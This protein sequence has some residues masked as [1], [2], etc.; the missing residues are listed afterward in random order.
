MTGRY[1]PEFHRL[2]SGRDRRVGMKD[3]LPRQY[4]RTLGMIYIMFKI[5]LFS[6]TL[7]YSYEQLFR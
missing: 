1:I 6:L 4:M 7:R 2:P 3:M 5:N